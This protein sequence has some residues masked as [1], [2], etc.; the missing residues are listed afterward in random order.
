MSRTRNTLRKAVA[1]VML[2]G[3]V[4]TGGVAANSGTASAAPQHADTWTNCGKYT[5]TTYYSRSDTRAFNTYFDGAAGKFGRIGEATFCGI[6]GMI[7]G[8]AVS[9]FAG[10]TCAVAGTGPYGVGAWGTAADNAVQHN[11]CLQA[12]RPRN[13]AGLLKPSYTTHSGYCFGK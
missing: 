13:G 3:A 9:A 2:V 1:G 7:G 11:G 4:A 12:E 6:V 5:C 10:A 8:P